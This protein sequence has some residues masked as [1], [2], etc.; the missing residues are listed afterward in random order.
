MSNVRQKSTNYFS[1]DSNARN[2]EKLVRLRMRHGAAGYGVYFMLLERLREETDYMSIK[3]YNMIA[4]DLRVDASLI[5]SVVE[6]FGL[7]AFTD[8]GKCFYSES[9]LR[10]MT[11]KDEVRRLRS[12]AGRRGGRPAKKQMLSDEKA[13]A[14]QNESKSF[15]SEKQNTDFAFKNE[16]KKSKGKKSKENL[17]CDENTPARGE[18]EAP[19]ETDEDYLRRF[20]SPANSGLIETLCMQLSLPKE[21]LGRLIP[22]I[23][24]E[25]QISG[26][27][28]KDYTD[29]ARHL[30]AQLRLKLSDRR[31]SGRKN[32]PRAAVDALTPEERNA[33]YY[34]ELRKQL[35]IPTS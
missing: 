31:R 22:E 33:R 3:D 32:N 7:F 8:D 26:L 14:F 15:N 20:T 30:I 35:N 4:F 5:K 12:E 19:P 17:V 25:W 28:H 16:S 27:R 24:A 2:D 18:P 34:D 29:W 6:D 10:R 23:L 21:D 1:H 11:L 13:N 9:F